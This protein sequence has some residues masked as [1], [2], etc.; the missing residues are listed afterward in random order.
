ME[1][2]LSPHESPKRPRESALE[3]GVVKA[4]PTAIAL[5]M[6]LSGSGR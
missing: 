4:I 2:K 3:E 1:R 6:H 5:K